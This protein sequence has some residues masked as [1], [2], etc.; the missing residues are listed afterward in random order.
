[1]RITKEQ[2]KKARMSLG[3]SQ[4]EFGTKLGLS[5]AA[6]SLLERGETSPIDVDETD[7]RENAWRALLTGDAEAIAQLP[8]P[9][10]AWLRSA[11]TRLR[12]TLAQLSDKCK[13]TDYRLRGMEKGQ[14]QPTAQVL[15]R[16]EDALGE[17]A[18]SAS[19]PPISNISIAGV[20][21]LQDFDPHNVN[22]RP[23]CAGVY[24]FYD[25]SDRSIYVGESKNIR[26]RIRQHEEKFWFKRPLVEYAA[27]IQ[28]DD[29]NL[30]KGIEQIL[31]NFLRS[32]AVLN[33]QHVLRD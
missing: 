26:L 7:P 17:Q 12:L 1:M 28:V 21:A 13:I 20:G 19:A 29:D 15:R 3:L 6:V 2:I 8:T 23:V 5:G 11:R 32:N 4:E 25:I 9:L 27:Y 31:I 22:D 24:V 10:A 14:H 18:P 16:L 30:R 33:R